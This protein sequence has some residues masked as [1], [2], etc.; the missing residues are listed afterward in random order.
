MSNTINDVQFDDAKNVR[1]QDDFLKSNFP[2]SANEYDYVLS[3]FKKV[4]KDPSTA[5]NFTQTLYQ[6]ARSSNTPITELVAQMKDQSEIEINETL[7]YYLNELRSGT[8][9]V[10]LRNP[11]VPAFYAARNVV[12]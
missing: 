11:L 2:V 7:A 3:F 5:E 4:M 6:V 9:L 8:A 10:G 12:I 1:V